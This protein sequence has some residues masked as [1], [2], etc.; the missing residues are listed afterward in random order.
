MAPHHNVPDFFVADASEQNDAGLAGWGF[1][2]L[3]GQGVEGLFEVDGLGARASDDE[4][5]IFVAGEEEGEGGDEEV[6]AF[7]V[8]ETGDYDDGDGVVG[9]DWMAGVRERGKEGG[10]VVGGVGEVEFV[11]LEGLEAGWNDGVGDH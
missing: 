11:G 5:Q 8:E 2:E 1:D 9:T 10:L 3:S 7:V 4:A 6:G